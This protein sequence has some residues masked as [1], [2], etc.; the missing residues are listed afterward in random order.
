V[1]FLYDSVTGAQIENYHG[2]IMADE[3]VCIE[4]KDIKFT[5]EYI[6]FFRVLVKHCNVL[7]FYGHYW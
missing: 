7:H 1:K 2:C 5:R 4:S 6:C 3:M